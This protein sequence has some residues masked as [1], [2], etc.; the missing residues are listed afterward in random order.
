MSANAVDYVVQKHRCV[1]CGMCKSSC[2]R[3]SDKNVIEV[4]PAIFT[5]ENS[6]CLKTDA[7]DFALRYVTVPVLTDITEYS[8]K[9]ARLA[10]VGMLCQMDAFSLLM[11]VQIIMNS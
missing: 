6:T 9:F 1:S 5:R 4:E 8:R 3:C 2:P 10:V 7:R 11:G